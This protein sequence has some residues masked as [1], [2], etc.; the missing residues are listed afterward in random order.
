MTGF[1][2]YK[3]IITNRSQETQ[4]IDSG[5]N[6]NWKW[7][8]CEGSYQISLIQLIDEWPKLSEICKHETLPVERLQQTESRHHIVHMDETIDLQLSWFSAYKFII[9]NCS[10]QTQ[11]IDSG[12]NSNWQWKG[13]EESYQ[14]SLIQL[15][16]WRYRIRSRSIELDEKRY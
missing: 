16:L 5:D 3:F 12:D 10:Q 6:T 15:I 11:P 7:T 4:L 14:M 2:A 1:S 8:G 9:T 13:C